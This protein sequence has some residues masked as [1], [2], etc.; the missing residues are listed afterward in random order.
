MKY[1]YKVTEKNMQK[2]KQF[3]ETFLEK[4]L[5]R[6]DGWFFSPNNF[7]NIKKLVT[8]GMVEF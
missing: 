4:Y 5:G 7:F 8:D 6:W 1:S 3:L 2:W